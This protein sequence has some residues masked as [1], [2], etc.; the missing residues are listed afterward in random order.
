[1]IF[2]KGNLQDLHLVVEPKNKVPK[3]KVEISP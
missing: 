2:P 3:E 1:M